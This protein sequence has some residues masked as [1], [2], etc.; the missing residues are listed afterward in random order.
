VKIDLPWNKAGW[1][2]GAALLVS[3]L[4]IGQIW[5]TWIEQQP[6]FEQQVAALSRTEPGA[7]IYPAFYPG[8]TDPGE[9]RDTRK[10]NQS[11]EHLPHYATILA[12]ALIPGLFVMPSTPID[13]KEK[14]PFLD[15][16]HDGWLQAAGEYDYIWLFDPEHTVPDHLLEAGG[17]RLAGGNGW[18]FWKVVHDGRAPKTAY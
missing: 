13:F 3:C 12:D 16:R 9:D 6:L 4:R 1:L 18:S 17:Q 2:L 15:V 11:Y 7:R 10:R 5:S 14:P 8:R